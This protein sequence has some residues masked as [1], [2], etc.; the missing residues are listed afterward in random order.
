MG[1]TNYDAASSQV[2][3]IRRDASVCS[4]AMQAVG[5]EIRIG[6][7]AISACRSALM[8]AVS[9]AELDGC[10][11]GEDWSVHGPS[12]KAAAHA[13]SI[14]A[15]LADL[16]RADRA[17]ANAVVGALDPLARNGGSRDFLPLVIGAALLAELAVDALIA[18]GV[19]TLGA[20]AFA[21]VD[22]FGEGAWDAI[23]SAIPDQFFA[24]AGPVDQG[25]VEEMLNKETEPGRN[26]P[27]R[28]VSS[29]QDVRDLYEAL[30]REGRPITESNYRGVGVLLPDGTAVRMRDSSTSGGPT[31]DIKFP[32]TPRPVKVHVS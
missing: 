8:S 19:V 24:D 30:S 9:A 23:S 6:S 31:I 20:L 7:D 4:T 22:Q 16:R 3:G 32:D 2:D 15:S 13:V 5:R 12:E 14:G 21:L 28:Q 1:R 18:T 26:P 10:V 17:A 27:I 29:E 11:V 25:G